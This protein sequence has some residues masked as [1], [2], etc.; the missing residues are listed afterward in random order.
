MRVD[1]Q[2][3]AGE[4]GY[5]VSG[6]DLYPTPAMR[7]LSLLS[8]LALL[9]T[10]CVVGTVLSAEKAAP[11]GSVDLRSPSLGDHTLKPAACR[12]GEHELF[13]G[14]D[15]LDSQGITTR[16]IVEPTGR[17]EPAVLR[18]GASSRSWHSVPSPGLRPLRALPGSHRL[19]DQRHLRPARQP[20]LRMPRRRRRDRD[21][22]SG[23]GS[24]PLSREA[25]RWASP[26]SAASSSSAPR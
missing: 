6:K 15:F 5:S 10:G 17:R 19:A 25:G 24:L 9:T 4:G 23:G 3:R 11:V 2:A 12:S 7:S 8:I 1:F 18:G 26:L 16:L 14:A 13:L 20:R 21:G 22:A